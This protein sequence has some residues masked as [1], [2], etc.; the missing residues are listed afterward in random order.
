MNLFLV[1]GAMKSGTTTLYH[2]LPQVP[3]IETNPTKEPNLFTVN[4]PQAKIAN[5]VKR[6]IG[7]RVGWVGDFSTSYTMD[8][9]DTGIAARARQILPKETP[10][11]YL[12]R[13]PLERAV[14]H[15]HHWLARGMATADVDH[16]LLTRPEYQAASSYASQARRWRK[17]FGQDAVQVIVFEDFV[18]NRYE[19]VSSIANRLRLDPPA[20]LEVGTYNARGGGDRVAT[21]LAGRLVSSRQYQLLGRRLI[22]QALRSRVGQA[23]TTSAPPRPRPTVGALSVLAERLSPEIAALVEDEAWVGPPWDLVETIRR[24]TEDQS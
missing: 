16:E 9:V 6:F 24:L 19:T 10:I 1:I 12:V 2:D 7:R 17:A 11:F 21:G 18:S 5:D 15:H 8:I 23:L 4:R 14:S 20:C 3:G 13:N 22:P